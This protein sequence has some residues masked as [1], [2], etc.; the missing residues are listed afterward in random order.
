MDLPDW[1]PT[2]G[3]VKVDVTVEDMVGDFNDPALYRST[4][5]SSDD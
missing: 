3:G 1:N 4:T 2:L 5:G